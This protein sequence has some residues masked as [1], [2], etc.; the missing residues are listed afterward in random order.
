M[1]AET[2]QAGIQ[3]CWF[4]SPSKQHLW[5][6]IPPSPVSKRLMLQAPQS[7]PGHTVSHCYVGR[8]STMRHGATNVETL[9]EAMQPADTFS[10]FLANSRPMH[11]TT[12]P[13]PCLHPPTVTELHQAALQ[14]GEPAMR[15]RCQVAGSSSGVLLSCT[16]PFRAALQLL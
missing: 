7:Q 12:I 13:S 10:I 15:M 5:N 8:S 6:G 11:H 9:L 16:D 1:T 3:T 2:Q 4:E 14:K